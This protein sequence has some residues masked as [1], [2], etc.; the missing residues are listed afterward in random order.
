M[1]RYLTKD[2]YALMFRKTKYWKF[3]YRK[4]RMRFC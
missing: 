2:L 3:F 4:E 1:K